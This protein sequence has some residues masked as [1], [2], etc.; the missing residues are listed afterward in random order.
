[1]LAC[2]VQSAEQSYHAQSEQYR[3]T[4]S[5]SN[6]EDPDALQSIYIA[7]REMR[8]ARIRYRRAAR[9]LRGFAAS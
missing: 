7:A 1:L 5:Q 8:M 3:Q 6:P 9:T 2:E 4:I